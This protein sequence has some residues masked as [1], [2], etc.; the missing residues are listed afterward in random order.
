M[1]R[2]TTGVAIA[3]L[4]LGGGV[5]ACSKSA[6]DSPNMTPAAAVAKAAKN[7]ED[8]TSLS[9]RMAGTVPE[10]GRVEAEASMAMKPLA[11]SMKMTALDQGAD[12]K[13]EIRLVD[14]AM[15]MGGGAAAAK[16]MDGKSWMKFDVSAMT[17]GASAGLGAGGLSDQANQDP[18]QESTFLTG[19]KDVKKVGTEKVDGVQTTHY[20]GTVTLDDLRADLKS[21][22]KATREKR[23]KSLKQYEDMGADKMTMDMWIDEDD[24]TKQFR[25]RADA[26]KGKF[27]VTMT[28]LD[29]NQPVTVKAPPAKDT[30]DLAEMMKEA[31]QG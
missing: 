19:S 22:D 13:V 29:F 12:G 14:G 9:Y 3:A 11:M 25:M 17:D 5:V 30:V 28:F 10:S 24:H 21:E 23:E 7:T 20:K 18:T 15:Y 31:Q 26:D 2:G 27:D 4:A 6:D 16:E 1:R 8:I